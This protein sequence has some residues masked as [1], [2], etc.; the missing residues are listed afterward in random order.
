M[1]NQEIKNAV[2][3][4]YILPTKRKRKRYVGVEFEL[5]VVNLN[6]EAVNFDIVHKLTDAFCRHFNFNKI[7]LDDDGNIFSAMSDKNG[8]DLSYDC[9]YNTLELSFGTECNLNILYERFK[10][11]YSFIQSYLLPYNHTLTGMGINPYRNYNKNEPVHSERY[12]MLFH[13]LSSYTKYTGFDFHNYPNFGFFSCASQVQLDVEED[14]II[15]VINTFSKLEPLKAMLFSNSP[16]NHDLMCSRDFLWKKS[17]HG[18]NPKNVDMFDKPLADIDEL[19]D[20]IAN[21]SMY[22]TMRSGKYINFAPTPLYEYFNCETIKGEYYENGEY[23]ET[24]FTPH[25]D[26]LEYLRSFKLEDLTFR[27]TVEFRSGCTQPVREIMALAAFHAGLMEKL[28]ELTVILDNDNVIYNHG[29]SPSELRD[30]FNHKALPDFA[31]RDELSKLLIKIIDL[32]NDGL[33]QRNMQEEAFILPLYSRAKHLFSP[34]KQMTD[35]IENGVALE[36]Y[37]KDYSKIK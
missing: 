36:Y 31:D 1:N 29:Y 13:H 16:L 7:Q 37:I 11:Y 25:I 32:A 23:K 3:Q 30:M 27:G 10:Q 24:E 6:K 28:S 19:V 8:D 9:S 34:A 14:S 33:K 20:Y 22:C 17:M 26:D 15:R 35:G 12:R 18:L 21:M 4:K 5:P 2:Y